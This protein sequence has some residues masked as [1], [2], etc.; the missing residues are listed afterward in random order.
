MTIRTA[1]TFRHPDRS[2]GGGKEVVLLGELMI[3]Y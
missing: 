2:S 3:G 1:G